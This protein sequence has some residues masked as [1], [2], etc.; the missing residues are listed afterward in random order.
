VRRSG[1]DAVVAFDMDGVFLSRSSAPRIAAIK[2]VL[3]DE[4]RFE[5]GSARVALGVQSWFERVHVRRADR[6]ITTS[7][8]A[9]DSIAAFYGPPRESIRILPEPLDLPRWRTA[10]SRTSPPPA[11]PPVILSVA[12]LYRRKDIATLLEAAARMKTPARLRIVG[13]GPERGRLARLCRR[14]GLDSRVTF[15]G[16]V[17][18]AE[19]AAEYRS[20]GI[21]CLPSR[22]EGFGIVLLEA[23]AAGLAVVAARA[24]AVPELVMDGKTGVLV[25][26]GDPETL[27]EAL[28]GRVS[29][30][31]SLP[32]TLPEVRP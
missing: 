26:P 14:R 9:A 23:M 13:D 21:F 1:A 25:P 24:G 4:R 10:L 7:R 3:A 30:Y 32:A 19:L 16:H 31:S 5:R 12:H 17:P 11:D 15:R 18:F 20:A 2:G 22:Q 27:A 6:V 8:Y 28:D 29:Q